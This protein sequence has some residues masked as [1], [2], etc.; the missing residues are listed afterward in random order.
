METFL[1]L[2]A[3][4][5]AASVTPGP[6][7]IMVAANAANNGARA[8]VPHIAGIT[9][10]FGAMIVLVGV[11]FAGVASELPGFA[12]ALR[13][14]ALAWLLYLAYRIATAPLPGQSGGRAPIGFVGAAM[15]QWVNPK[16]WLMS[17]SVVSAFIAPDRAVLP[18]LA[19][20]A[21]VFV[22]VCLPSCSLWA[23]IGLGAAR[24]LHSPG[25]LRAFNVA[26]ALLLVA[27][28]LPVALEH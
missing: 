22:M 18:Q 10:G 11:G 23:M 8:V 16:A 12:G 3:F 1:P 19:V 4:A 5:I 14:V 2:L 7:N 25:R 27:S 21:G 28:M 13:W 26:M 6:N 9:V 15:F 17:L 24:V 20:V